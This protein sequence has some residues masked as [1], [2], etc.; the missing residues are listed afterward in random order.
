LG[1]CI[2]SDQFETVLSPLYH[3]YNRKKTDWGKFQKN[4]LKQENDLKL[5]WDNIFQNNKTLAVVDRGAEL[6]TSTIAKAVNDSRPFYR[7]S[8]RPKVWWTDQLKE[9]STYMNSDL[10]HWKQNR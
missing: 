1:L 6:I 7:S 3:K 4:L 5:E 8:P 9:L 10:R 2:T